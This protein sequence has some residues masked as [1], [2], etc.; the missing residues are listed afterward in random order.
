MKKFLKIYDGTYLKINHIKSF[1]CQK[2]LKVIESHPIYACLDNKEQYIVSIHK[3][4]ME[5]EIALEFLIEWIENDKIEK[6]K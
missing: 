6:F 2:Q 3:S 1:R 4:Q 5:C